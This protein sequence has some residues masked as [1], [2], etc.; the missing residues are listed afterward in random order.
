MIPE[1]TLDMVRVTEAAALMASLYLGRGNKEMVDQYAVDA[2]RGILDLIDMRGTVVIGEG[3]KDNAPMLYPGEKV[4]KWGDDDPEVLIAVDPIDGTRLVAGGRPNAISVIAATENGEIAPL[5]THYVDKLAVGKELA[6]HLDIEATPRENLRIAAAILGVK[7]SELTVAVL[8]RE[9]NAE[10]IEAIRSVGARIKLIDDG[11]IAGAISTALPESGIDI[12]MGVGGSPE[13]V[14]AAAALQCL[15]GEI[16][17]KCW[18]RND[19]EIK[20]VEK[21]GFDINKTYRTRDLINGSEVIFSA[22]GVTDGSF[23]KGVRFHQNQA[24]TDSIV[25][26]S[27]T[28]TIRRIIAYHDLEFKTITTKTEGEKKLIN[29]ANWF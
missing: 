1:I 10:L 13:G 14:L 28:K 4:G 29:G 26:R 21:A 19:E 2:M 5:P 8:D 20:K 12:Y 17:V 9:R 27:S 25:M 6:G 7:V 24:V 16:Q 18:A 11:D 3:E 15:G 23:L 22:T